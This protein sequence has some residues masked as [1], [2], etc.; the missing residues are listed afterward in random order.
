MVKENFFDDLLF[1]DKDQINDEIFEVLQKI[2]EFETFHPSFV[3]KS[4]KAAAG[5]CAWILSI[6][7]YSKVSRSQ[8]TKIEQ[9]KT[10]Q[11]LYNKVKRKVLFN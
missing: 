3:I 7:E 4:S 2:V 8:R 10:Y 1:Y 11:E 6:Y 9:V 5:L